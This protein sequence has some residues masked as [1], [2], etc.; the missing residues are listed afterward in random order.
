ME[1]QK[2]LKQI[3]SDKGWY[4]AGFVDGEGSFNVSFARKN[5][6]RSGWQITPS[7]NVS[8]RDNTNLF[9]LKKYL[10]CGRLKRRKDG[11]WIFVVENP[12]SLQERV[13]PFFKRFNLLSSKAK[14]N[15]SLFQK[16]VNLIVSDKHLTKEG[17]EQIAQIREK[18]NEGRGRKRKFNLSDIQSLKE[19]SET[20]R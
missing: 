9:L 12:N 13:I 6:Y 10:G 4:L 17:L 3:P 14:T 18:L 16:I 19:S 15:F 20:I 1:N 5:D 7:F 8:Q 2:W 11:C